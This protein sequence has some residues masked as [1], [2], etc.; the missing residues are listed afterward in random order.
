MTPYAFM[1]YKYTL[2]IVCVHVKAIIKNDP[3]AHGSGGQEATMVEQ[4]DDFG[5]EEERRQEETDHRDE[6]RDR[7]EEQMT[8]ETPQDQSQQSVLLE[9]EGEEG[10]DQPLGADERLDRVT[11]EDNAEA[12]LNRMS[13]HTEDQEILDDFAERQMMPT[14]E[15]GMT[16]RMRQHHSETPDVTG[17]DVDAAWEQGEDVGDETPS[18][19]PMPDH[20]RVGEMG[21]ALGVTY[22]DDEPLDF[23]EKVWRRDEERFEMMPE[24]ATG[25]VEEAGLE[26]EQASVE[27]ESYV[28]EVEGDFDEQERDE[29]VYGGVEPYED[30]FEEGEYADEEEDEMTEGPINPLDFSELD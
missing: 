5:A 6:H 7:E 17:G 22:E 26:D 29:E 8:T 30:E 10:E 16:R 4:R 23:A 3:P 25:A 1:A 21:E 27:D 24:S 11:A 28:E 15:Q 14:D 9:L 20:D 13:D 18:T 2:I 12:V 19:E